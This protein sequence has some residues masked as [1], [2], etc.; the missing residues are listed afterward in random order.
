VVKKAWIIGAVLGA[1]AC[2]LAFGQIGGKTSGDPRVKR[3]LDSLGYK[4]KLTNNH[5]FEL[6]FEV[7]D[8]RSQKVFISSATEKYKE[9]EIREVYS[10]CY[11]STKPL[12]P[13]QLR[14]LLTDSGDKK[15]GGWILVRKEDGDVAVFTVK[16]AADV[17]EDDMET[18]MQLVTD[19]ADVMEKEL[20]G[21]DDL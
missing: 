9:F 7:G 8:G 16:A 2:G 3:L 21:T 20:T 4:Y 10:A 15:L 13:D 17:T 12:S 11:R 5:D 19:A 14:R 6:V 1:M 18:L